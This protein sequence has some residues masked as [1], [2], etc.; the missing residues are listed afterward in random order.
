MADRATPNLPSRNFLKT[1]QFYSKLGFRAFYRSGHW[2]ILQ[3][4][5]KE[6]CVQLEFFPWPDLDPK[7]NSH[8]CCVRLDEL[9]AL[10]AQAEEAGVSIARTGIPRMVPPTRDISGLTIA[11]LVDPDGSLLRLVQNPPEA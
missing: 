1:E 11:Y 7:E 9:D 2:L 3:R 4:G 6:S 5:P 10:V 8:S